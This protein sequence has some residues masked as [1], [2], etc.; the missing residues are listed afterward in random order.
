MVISPDNSKI[1]FNRDE[2][3]VVYNLLEDKTIFE[4]KIPVYC[5][6]QYW[7]GEFVWTSD[8]QKLIYEISPIGLDSKSPCSEESVG[9]VDGEK[10]YETW[11]EDRYGTY[12]SDGAYI[13][14]TETGE[15]ERFFMDIGSDSYSPDDSR[16]IR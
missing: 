9:T 16:M 2:T 7:L 8:S 1:A 5:Y 13:V 10:I 15:V 11:Y 3:V 4:K 12:D 14:D 6:G